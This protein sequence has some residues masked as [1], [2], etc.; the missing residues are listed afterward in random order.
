MIV[1]YSEYGTVSE[2]I[3]NFRKHGY[4]IDF[5]LDENCFVCEGNNKFKLEE[6]KIAEIYR[7]DGSSEPSDEAIIY[8]IESKSGLKGILMTEGIY[9]DQKTQRMLD[10]L[11]FRK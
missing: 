2:A 9:T 8:A 6:F 5:N 10:K 1:H 7:Y 11:E 3:N 4:T